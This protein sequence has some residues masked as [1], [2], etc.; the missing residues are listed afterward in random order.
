MSLKLLKC[1]L[2]K[3]F[4][5]KYKHKLSS[6]LFASDN[7]AKSIYSTLSRAFETV[8]TDL[9]VDSLRELHYT[10]NPALSQSNKIVLEE[11]FNNLKNLNLTTETSEIILKNA[12]EQQLWTQLSKVSIDGGIGLNSDIMQAQKLLNSLKEGISLDRQVKTVTD[13]LRELL[14]L[15]KQK[16]KWKFNLS[17][18]QPIISGIGPNI[19][20]LVAARTNVGKTGAIVSFV[21]APEGFLEQG[22]HVTWLATEES[23]HK[24]KLRM[25]IATSGFTEAE[26]N[27]DKFEEAQ[28]KFNLIKDN[29]HVLDVN[30]YSIEELD[31][32]LSEKQHPTDILVVDVLDKL[33]SNDSGS[34]DVERQAELYLMFRELLKRHDIAGIGTSQ[35][36]IDADNVYLFG[37]ESLSNSKTAKGGE[38]DLC[39]CIGMKRQENWKDNGT[40]TINVAKNKVSG[41]HD[42]VNCMLNITLNRF[43]A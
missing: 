31:A 20:T 33:R 21:A 41:I 18:L 28:Q 22:A 43:V 3:E 1:L 29:L 25:W 23:A 2:Y 17:T 36:G 32:Y 7:N 4:Y 6:E 35:A 38:L 34:Q 16:Y 5:D 26:M 12:L 30:N 19:F 8:K 10:Y 14:E 15:S 9:N 40:R 27:A 11:F 42:H 37:T 24:T 39:L 13:D